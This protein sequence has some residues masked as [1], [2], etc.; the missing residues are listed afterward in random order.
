MIIDLSMHSWYPVVNAEGI[1][2]YSHSKSE[3]NYGMN[4]KQYSIPITDNC[5][6]ALH[7]DF[8]KSKEHI[9]MGELPEVQRYL[10][11]HKQAVI[12]AERTREINMQQR[13]G[14][15]KDGLLR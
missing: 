3:R 9:L 5:I 11:G 6:I 7:L 1:Y 12:L 13:G 15:G 14:R 2:L 4:G 8:E 10:R